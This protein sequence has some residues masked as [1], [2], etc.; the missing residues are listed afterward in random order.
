MS[1]TPELETRTF[2][3]L[4]W[5]YHGAVGHRVHP[6]MGSRPPLMLCSVTSS[7]WVPGSTSSVGFIC[8]EDREE[9]AEQETI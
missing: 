1:P 6:R 3:W 5:D 9:P 8:C 4:N 7:L 2:S